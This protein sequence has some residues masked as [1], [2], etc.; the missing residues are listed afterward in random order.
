[1]GKSIRTILAALLLIFAAVTEAADD[2]LADEDVTSA[3]DRVPAGVFYA[4][5]P[6]MPLSV[7]GLHEILQ[8]G[9]QLGIEVIPVLSSHANMNYAR[10]R[11]EGRDLPDS[12][13][14]QGKSK[15]LVEN[16]LFVHA[17]AILIFAGGEFISPVI[18]GFRYAD[19]YQ[20]LIGRF[21]A[22]ANQESP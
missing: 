3:L 15:I 12:V 22:Q 14:R 6:H 1:M 4:W 5:S 11:I 9:D 19:D 16:N 13:L 10:D 21:L 20:E 8:V 17:P 18:P 2:F 7:D